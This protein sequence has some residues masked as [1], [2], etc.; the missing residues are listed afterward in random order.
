MVPNIQEDIEMW[1]IISVKHI[2]RKG[3]VTNKGILNTSFN[4]NLNFWSEIKQGNYFGPFKR[5]NT[6][7]VTVVLVHVTIFFFWLV[8]KCDPNCVLAWLLILAPM[9]K[10]C[11][12]LV[13]LINK[14]KQFFFY[15]W[16]MM[17]SLPSIKLARSSPVCEYN[18]MMGR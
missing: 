4:E 8:D 14:L 7:L 12:K 13:C 6:I 2:V 11:Q 1:R 16:W 10:G 18:N 3:K 9:V 5:Y 17:R 15:G